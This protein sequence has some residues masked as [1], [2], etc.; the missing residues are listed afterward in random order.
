MHECGSMRMAL[1]HERANRK[2][3][4][5]AIWG[6]K[7]MLQQKHSAF[8]ETRRK[9]KVYFNF[10]VF[11]T[12]HASLRWVK[13][14]F[15]KCPKVHTWASNLDENGVRPSHATHAP[16][17]I[18]FGGDQACPTI[19]PR[20]L[21]NNRRECCVG[22]HWKPCM[23]FEEGNAICNYCLDKRQSSRTQARARAMDVDGVKVKLY[24]EGMVI[25]DSNNVH[26]P[27]HTCVQDEGGPRNAP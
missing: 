17:T 12:I 27:N 16:M 3:A 19:T 25:N 10:L 26:T 9:I 18:D 23:D 6:L 20:V 13:D 1:L 2:L 8:L 14:E 21:G 24:F 4:W 7:L 11:P 22:Q 15:N 5:F